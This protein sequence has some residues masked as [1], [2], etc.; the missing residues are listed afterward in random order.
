M[1]DFCGAELSRRYATPKQRGGRVINGGH[2]TTGVETPAYRRMSLRDGET[3]RRISIWSRRW[4]YRWWRRRNSIWS[5]PN[6]ISIWSSS[7]RMTV[8]GRFNARCINANAVHQ[9]QRPVHQ[10]PFR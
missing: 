6:H 5:R 7:D 10:R 4:T 2:L 1:N 8:A 3:I 9:R